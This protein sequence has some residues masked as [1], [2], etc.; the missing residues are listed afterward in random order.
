MGCEIYKS[1][2]EFA[3]RAPDPDYTMGDPEWV[4]CRN[5]WLLPGAS[6]SVGE[7]SA[8]YV[9]SENPE[10]LERVMSFE[11]SI[12]YYGVIRYIDGLT[13]EECET[14]FCYKC[15]PSKNGRH[16]LFEGGPP[17]YLGEKRSPKENQNPN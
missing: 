10:L 5:D 1:Q 13:E 8:D 14:R 12:W 3:K 4:F 11:E 6:I 7:Y 2:E 9:S 16:L 15:A 17:A